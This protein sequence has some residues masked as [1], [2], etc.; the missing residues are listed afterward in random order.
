MISG[1]SHQVT[2]TTCVFVSQSVWAARERRASGRT[3]G[4]GRALAPPA[5][6]HHQPHEGPAAAAAAPR[7]RACSAAKFPGAP[8]EPVA[9]FQRGPE[10]PP[11]G[12]IPGP[13]LPPS[14]PRA[15]SGLAPPSC[16]ALGSPGA[17]RA[18]GRVAGRRGAGRGR[19]RPAASA[20]SESDFQTR[21]RV[22]AAPGQPRVLRARPARAA[23]AR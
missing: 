18:A 19:A 8:A 4:A 5:G 9:G 17:A 22:S 6:A 16:P 23:T 2:S 3:H 21:A 7:A 14:S 1:L 13:P 10:S 11:T 20:P 15:G 12:K